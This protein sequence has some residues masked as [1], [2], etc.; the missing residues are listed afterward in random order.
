[1]PM[2]VFGLGLTPLRRQELD[3]VRGDGDLQIH[4]LLVAEA[5]ALL[6]GHRVWARL[7][8]S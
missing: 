6:G 3:T 1:M 4:A 2:N 7:A 5:H 8:I